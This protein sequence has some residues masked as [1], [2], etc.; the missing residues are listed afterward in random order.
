MKWVPYAF[1]KLDIPKDYKQD[2]EIYNFTI[3]IGIE[4]TNLNI[5]STIIIDWSKLYIDW[6]KDFELKGT[7]YLIGT[8]RFTL[9][10]PNTSITS[11]ALD[12]ISNIRGNTIIVTP[13][14]NITINSEI[15]D[16]LV[17]YKIKSVFNSVLESKDNTQQSEQNTPSYSTNGKSFIYTIKGQFIYYK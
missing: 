15:P 17:E 4:Y 14:S 16:E 13:I 8:T 11:T 3:R 12:D 5:G 9:P 10:T 7:H 6:M 1:C 2:K